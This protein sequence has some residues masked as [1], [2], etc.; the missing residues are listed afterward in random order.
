MDSWNVGLDVGHA[1]TD[2]EHRG[3]Y[4]L[5]ARA[6]VALEREDPHGVADALGDLHA[7]SEVHFGHEEA[8]MVQSAFEG[9]EAHR[10]AHRAFMADFGKL[11][12]ELRA[13]GLSPLFRLWFGSRFQ[14]WLRLH[15]R[16]QDAQFYRHLRQWQEAQARAAEARLVAE[17]GPP[18]RKEGPVEGPV[19][20]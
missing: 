3:L 1:D 4:A 9:L 15:I 11:L 13:R 5:T 6:A 8:L 7:L 18:P 2:A 14:D 19:R 12:A 10:E 16:G 17:G 20:E